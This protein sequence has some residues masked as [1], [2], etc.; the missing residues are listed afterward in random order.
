MYAASSEPRCTR[1]TC[2]SSYLARRRSLRLLVSR[3][4]A[5]P[6]LRG[7][8]QERGPVGEGR[9]EARA[10]GRAVPRCVNV[11]CGT[12]VCHRKQGGLPGLCACVETLQRQSMRQGCLQRMSGAGPHRKMVLGMSMERS[13]PWYLRPG[14]RA[15]KAQR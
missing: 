13:M 2:C 12:C 14:Q 11:G 7:R 15:A 3:M 8:G 10:G 6:M 5:E 4:A 1:T 9:E